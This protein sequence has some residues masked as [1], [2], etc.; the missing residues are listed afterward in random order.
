[1]DRKLAQ[2]AHLATLPERFGAW[3]AHAFPKRGG[4]KVKEVSTLSS[5][6]QANE[7]YFVT[8]DWNDGSGVEDLV[9]RLPPP[10]AGRLFPEY[11]LRKQA[12]IQLLLADNG[13]PA[14]RPLACEDDPK[15]LG[16]VFLVMPRVAGRSPSDRPRYSDE[17]WVKDLTAAGRGKVLYGFMD[18][19]A[20]VH[21]L[22]VDS[23]GIRAV[24]GRSGSGPDG[25]RKEWQW[26]NQYLDWFAKAFDTSQL[27][28]DFGRVK[29]L[30]EWCDRYW[31]QREPPPSLIWGD[32]RPGNTLYDDTAQVTALLDWEMIS[33]GP[34]EIDMG[35]W[36]ASRLNKFEMLPE[37]QGMPD[38]E[39]SYTYYQERLG[40]ELRDIEWYEVFGAARI[41]AMI[42]GLTSIQRRQGRPD[43]HIPTL[44]PW[45]AERTGR[46]DG[47]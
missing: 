7:M 27:S 35:W 12:A 42:C 36:M 11:D 19:M 1:M 43:F 33:V 41:G 45:V 17:G 47:M 8:V 21:R 30:F 10:V 15:W 24:A 22:Y 2:N 32:P 20:Q 46:L 40:R 16:E 23:T 6:G 44:S 26:W 5:N 38:R 13:I 39:Q 3:L 18:A 37:L 34:A 28:A 14:V 29:A 9:V 31:P 4:A 25:L